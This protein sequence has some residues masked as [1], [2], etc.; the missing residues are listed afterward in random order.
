MDKNT[1]ITEQKDNVP[2]YNDK[3]GW[4]LNFD[5]TLDSVIIMTLLGF[6]IWR[7]FL[8]PM[9][10]ERFYWVIN[11]FEEERKIPI[12][13][14]QIQA[15][16]DAKCVMVGSFHNGE[17]DSRGYHLK[18][19]S[20]IYHWSQNELNQRYL[21]ANL[22]IDNLS[23]SVRKAMESN[24]W[25]HVHIEENYDDECQSYLREN[26]LCAISMRLIQMGNI[27]IGLLTIQYDSDDLDNSLKTQGCYGNAVLDELFLQLQGLMKRRFQHS[28]QNA[29]I[30]KKL[31][32]NN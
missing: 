27:P 8:R 28:I 3:D 23:P 12:L 11:P 18:K 1:T 17:V 5:F 6:A 4:H 30:F 25:A 13:L 2:I 20:V 10:V 21:P 7:K 22:L 19:Y 29:N 16:A 14:A 9:L 24:E 32:Q 31:F 26:N 15:V